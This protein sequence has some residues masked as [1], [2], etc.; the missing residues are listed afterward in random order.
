MEKLIEDLN[1]ILEV[2]K[3]TQEKSESI[4]AWYVFNDHTLKVELGIQSIDDSVEEIILKPDPKSVFLVRELISGLGTI[5]IYVPKSLLIFSAE[6]KNVDDEGRI[7]IGFPTIFKVHD[8]RGWDRVQLEADILATFELKGKNWNKKVFDLGSGGMSI[9][10]NK[11]EHFRGELQEKIPKVTITVG[12]KK[13]FCECTIVNILQLKPYLLE[14]CPYGG[15]RVSFKF[16]NLDKD[17]KE[18]LDKVL[19][20]HI[21]LLNDLG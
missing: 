18:I 20:S 11:T 2:L 16:D 3:E 10:F 7:K 5:N 6:F 13:A 14:N 17:S 12:E 1:D 21:G 19:L 4:F 15:T 9:V 8:R